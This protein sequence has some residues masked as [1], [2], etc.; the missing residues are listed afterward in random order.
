[1]VSCITA[2]KVPE[3]SQGD[4]G[5]VITSGLLRQVLTLKRR[6]WLCAAHT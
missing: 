3:Q 2:T 4:E 1:M 5:S 6:C